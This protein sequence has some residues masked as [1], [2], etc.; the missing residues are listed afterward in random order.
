MKHHRN[1]FAAQPAQLR[2]CQFCQGLLPK[3][4]FALT[5]TGGGGQQPRNGKGG[6][7]FAA[8]GFAH[9][10]HDLAP[11]KLKCYFAERGVTPAF[12]ADVDPQPAQL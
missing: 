4:Y 12:G 1:F 9:K 3:A 8:T 10:A 7:A 2:L 5:H 6:E 11:A